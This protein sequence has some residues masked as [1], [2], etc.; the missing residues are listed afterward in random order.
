MQNRPYLGLLAVS[1]VCSCRGRWGCASGGGR[2]A[3][4]GLARAVA[5]G[6]AV[7]AE[8]ALSLRR[9]CSWWRT[10]K[11]A[12]WGLHRGSTQLGRGQ[13]P[14][15]LAAPATTCVTALGGGCRASKSKAAVAA[16]AQARHL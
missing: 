4:S 11:A 1:R 8:R 15:E 5:A 10:V 3:G 7:A 2:D 9:R 16:A 13:V 6:G 14:T 12:Q